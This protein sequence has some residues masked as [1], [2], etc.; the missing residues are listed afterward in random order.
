MK[1]PKCGSKNIFV[2]YFNFMGGEFLK[3]KCHNCDYSWEEPTE[4]SKLKNSK[5]WKIWEQV[6]Q[7]LVSRAAYLKVIDL[8]AM[9]S[10]LRKESYVYRY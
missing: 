2:K 5:K 1:C 7:C 9:Q 8:K 3:K 6:R 10:H 4:D